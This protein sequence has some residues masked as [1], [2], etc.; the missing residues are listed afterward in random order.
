MVAFKKVGDSILTIIIIERYIMIR[1]TSSRML[2]GHIISLV[3][4]LASSITDT[5]YIIHGMWNLLAFMSIDSYYYY[6]REIYHGNTNKL[7]N[8]DRSHYLVLHIYMLV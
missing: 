3:S 4:S 5:V 2:I 7:K 1:Q 6:Y 8:V